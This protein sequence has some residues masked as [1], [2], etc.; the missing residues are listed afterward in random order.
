MITEKSKTF[1]GEKVRLDDEL[2]ILVGLAEIPT[3]SPYICIKNNMELINSKIEKITVSLVSLESGESAIVAPFRL[4]T[5]NSHDKSW[6]G[7]LSK[8]KILEELETCQKRET[9]KIKS[10]GK[11]LKAKFL[12][13]P[14]YDRFMRN[15]E[16]LELEIVLWEKL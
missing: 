8:D 15:L 16:N 9:N 4:I 6:E 7:K 14:E 3:Y 12:K 13:Y 10:V 11:L 2:G 1:L 5:T